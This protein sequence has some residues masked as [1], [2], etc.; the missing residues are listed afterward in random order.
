MSP[1]CNHP[2][3]PRCHKQ[4]SAISTLPKI[5][6]QIRIRSRID[7]NWHQ[8]TVSQTSP[9]TILHQLQIV[10][11]TTT[12]IRVWRVCPRLKYSKETMTKTILAFR[13]VATWGLC[14]QAK[15]SRL[16][17]VNPFFHNI[18]CTEMSP[19]YNS[20]LKVWVRLKVEWR[21]FQTKKY[22]KTTSMVKT[23]SHDQKQTSLELMTISSRT[24]DSKI[25]RIE[26]ILLSLQFM[27]IINHTLWMSPTVIV[28]NQRWNGISFSASPFAPKNSKTQWHDLMKHQSLRNRL[29]LSRTSKRILMSVMRVRSST[30][31]QF[32]ATVTHTNSSFYPIT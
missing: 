13:W 10:L 20:S 7:L 31:T 25:S 30:T 5:R 22:L 24:W 18:K 32:L 26:T 17:S 21:Q 27:I 16:T 4:M 8:M 12:S 29:C 15:I 1:S 23:T 19:N 28:T 11:T 14:L 3:K 6:L 9:M 2:K